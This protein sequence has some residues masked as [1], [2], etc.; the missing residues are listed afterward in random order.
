MFPNPSNVDPAN[1]EGI[2]HGFNHGFNVT[3]ARFNANYSIISDC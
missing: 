2:G 1:C 3:Q